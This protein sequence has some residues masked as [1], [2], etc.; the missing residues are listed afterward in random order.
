VETCNTKAGWGPIRP[1]VS[2]VGVEW[3][4]NKD[5]AM[6]TSNPWDKDIDYF[7]PLL[8]HLCAGENKNEISSYPNMS[9]SGRLSACRS[10]AGLTQF[11]FVRPNYRV[12]PSTPYSSAKKT[13]PTSF[14]LNIFLITG[15]L[16][17]ELQNNVLN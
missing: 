1:G 17:L 12:N 10:T 8:S 3:M 14:N 16:V 4:T 7:W 5:V 6:E 15:D 9:A 2:L 13:F 11:F